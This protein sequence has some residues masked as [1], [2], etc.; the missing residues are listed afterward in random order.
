MM[1]P[2]LAIIYGAACAG[3]GFRYGWAEAAVFFVWT[4]FAVLVGAA[5]GIAHDGDMLARQWQAE[6]LAKLREREHEHDGYDDVTHT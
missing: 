5:M 2:F 6:Q 1:G 3:V 4:A